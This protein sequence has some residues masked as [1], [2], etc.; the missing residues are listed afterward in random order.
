MRGLHKRKGEVPIR[1][2]AEMERSSV[3]P[4]R[5]TRRAE[6]ERHGTAMATCEVCGNQYDKTFEVRVDGSKHTFDSF[7]CAIQALAPRCAHCDCRVIGHG[8]E[9]RGR[10]FCC[11]HCAHAAG[12]ADV[13]DR[14]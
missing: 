12:G 4:R 14:A 10:I 8:V 9:E 7:E 2:A 5:R 13:R 11:A 1:E 6:G 3:G